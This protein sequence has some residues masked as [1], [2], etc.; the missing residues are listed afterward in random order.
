MKK[1]IWI[2]Y[3]VFNC[4]LIY[5]SFFLY[6]S[7]RHPFFWQALS[8][9]C[10]KC[11]NDHIDKTSSHQDVFTSHQMMK[12]LAFGPPPCGRDYPCLTFIWDM[13]NWVISRPFLKSL[14]LNILRTSCV[15]LGCVQA[16]IK[17]GINMLDILVEMPIN[18]K[19]GGN[20]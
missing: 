10:F 16:D 19:L 6:P 3:I 5:F 2:S 15:I 8:P 17:I 4:L 14:S 11:W 7:V 12:S 1:T 20:E 18:D 13:A 9:T